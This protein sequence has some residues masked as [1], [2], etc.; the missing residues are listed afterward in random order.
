MTV[1]PSLFL[2]HGAPDL[3]ISDHTAKRFLNRLADLLPRPRA[4]LIISAHWETTTTAL[5]TAV[6]PST[7]HDF[8]GWPSS[9]YELSYPAHTDAT[10]IERTKALLDTAG[11]PVIEDA[12]RGYDH[13]AWVPLLLSYSDAEIPVV[14]LSMLR[15]SNTKQQFSFGQALAPLRQEGVLIIGS[16]ATVHNLYEMSPEGT[17]APDWAEGFDQW[18]FDCIERR[19]LEALLRFPAEPITAQRAH[20]S[21]EHFLPIYLAMGAGWDGGFARRLHHSYSYGS[22]GMACYAF[23]HSTDTTIAPIK[24]RFKT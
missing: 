10:L 22:I 13:G 3:V 11:V 16:G 6:A 1:L 4:I 9:L 18:L 24:E 20:P 7:V 19:N 21:I 8:T 17:P 15:G 14:Q 12:V 5:T 23:G 2:A